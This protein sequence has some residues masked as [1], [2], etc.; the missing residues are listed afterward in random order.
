MNQAQIENKKENP[1]ANIGF[2]IVIPVV[3]LNQ[4]TDR[5]GEHGP[6]I[7]LVV[8]LAFPLG[9]GAYDLIVNKRKNFISVL[10]IVNIL[11][12]GGL[13]LLKVEGF[14]FA[15]KEAAF[16]ALIGVGVYFTAYTK[17]PAVK[18][19]VYNKNV[20]DVDRV[21]SVLEEKGTRTQFDH[22]L[23]KSTYL[24]AI[25]FF[26]SAILNFGL[27]SYIFKDIDPNLSSTEAASVLN[28]QIADMQ[29]MSFIVIALPLT[30]F[31]MYIL[32]YVKNGITRYTGLGVEDIF[33]AL[34]EPP[35]KN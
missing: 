27:A 1:L 16:P 21:E 24:L 33:P 25:S 9:Y 19:M 17:K 11:F 2:N 12:T 5:F 28:E 34:K 4:L 10:G 32:F 15:V 31:M 30:V 3:L 29:W 7:A 13:A 14:W 22:H 18:M 6:L 26:L 23:K 20:M 8:A 35:S